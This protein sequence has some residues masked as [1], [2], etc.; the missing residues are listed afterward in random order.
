MKIDSEC[1]IGHLPMKPLVE[2]IF[3]LRW[4]IQATADG[5]YRDP[6]WGLLPGLYF[7]K[8]QKDYPY[9][10]KLPA[11]DLPEELTGYSVRHRFR[12]AKDDWPLIQ[13]GPGILTLN[14]TTKYTVWEEFRPRVMNAVEA[15]IDVYQGELK[16]SQ[17]ELR[18]INAVPYDENHWTPTE[19]LKERLH[20]TASIST[21]LTETNDSDL[22][23]P[24]AFSLNFTVPLVEPSG[25][26]LIAFATAKKDGEACLV[27]HLKV[28]SE[29]SGLPDVKNK[30]A[31]AHWLDS[32]HSIIDRWFVKL[33][34]GP[35]LESFRGDI[36]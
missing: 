22:T 11:A 6:G 3:E 21:D 1:T 2:A 16:P 15:L 32:A 9:N 8:V 29:T 31:L 14:E 27:W 17:I 10:Q 30:A 25:K 33:A 28:T 4:E 5:L 35:L 20:T 36:K 18:Y 19:F 24:S 13:I 12:R 26:G 7:G 34:E 23:N